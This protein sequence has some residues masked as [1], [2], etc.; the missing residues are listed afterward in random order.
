MWTKEFW[1]DATERCIG[2]M[3]EVLIPMLT[4]GYFKEHN[5]KESA[6]VVVLSGAACLCKCIWK[7]TGKEE[8]E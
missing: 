7:A 6:A 1:R 4:L 8:K 3:A 2:T 5:W